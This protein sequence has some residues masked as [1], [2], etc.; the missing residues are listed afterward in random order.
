MEHCAIDLGGRKSQ[1]C[2]R[3]AQGDILHE[4][5]CETLSLP[6]YLR[7]LPRPLRVILETS[8]EAFSI[9]DAAKAAGHEVRV[10]PAT[11][12]RTLGVGERRTKTDVR[13]AR[14]LSEVSSRIDL[15][16]VH[17]ASARSREWKTMCG[18]HDALVSSRTKLINNLR[19]WLR[20]QG[21][22][23]GRGS[24]ETFAPR[25]NLLA[26]LPEYIAPQVAVI[27]SITTQIIES[28]KRMRRIA[29]ADELCRRLMTVPGIGP[30][31]ALRFVAAIDEVGRF[32]SPH[33]VSAYLGLTPGEYQ[34]STTQ[35]RLGITKAGPADV[36]WVLVQAAHCL[37]HRCRSGAARPLQLWAVEI[38]KR[39]GKR[40][41]LV[42][43]ARKLS[44][45]LFALWRDG[46]SFEL[47]RR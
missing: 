19:G 25:M 46:T 9:A 35:H 40:I 5:R 39:R 38:E 30:S 3:S 8:A 20:G 31:T 42:A 12:V 45:I 44:G 33:K 1:V 24:T 6:E 22:R 14:V 13:D 34:S 37:R 26:P 27:E 43:L 11:L 21:K 36:R 47:H 18:A 10:V 15:P 2:I 41:A 17:I 16:S 28:E 7:S 23:L 29:Q 4:E 32:E